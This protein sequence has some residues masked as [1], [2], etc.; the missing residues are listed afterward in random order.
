[1]W[2]TFIIENYLEKIPNKKDGRLMAF[3]P[4]MKVIILNL[5]SIP[6]DVKSLQLM[7]ALK[8]L[9]PL[10]FLEINMPFLK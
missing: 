8:A 2:K 3:I 7:T 1:M 4:I 10:P 6:L 9:I 5:F